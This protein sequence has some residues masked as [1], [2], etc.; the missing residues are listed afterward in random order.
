MTG[1]LTLI[2]LITDRRRLGGRELP[3]LAREAAAAGVDRVQ[4]REKDL[5]GRGLRALVSEIV[6]LL[7]SCTGRSSITLTPRSARY[8]SRAAHLANVLSNP[9]TCIS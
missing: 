6:S 3:A 1:G 7:D 9:L 8:G 4:V 5:S 2:T